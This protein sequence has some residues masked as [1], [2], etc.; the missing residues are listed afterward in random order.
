MV[1]GLIFAGPVFL[2]TGLYAVGSRQPQALQQRVRWTLSVSF[3]I[4][5][6]A[7]TALLLGAGEV[8][9]FFGDAYADSAGSTLRVLGLAVFPLIVRDHYVAIRRLSGRLS[10][11]A[12]FVGAGAVL[13]LALAAIGAKMGGVT[14]L[15]F[16]W[17]AAIGIEAVVMAD[18]VARLA[19]P[20]LTQ[21]LGSLGGWPRIP[22]CGAARLCDHAIPSQSKHTLGVE[23]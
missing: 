12:L 5:V 18:P 17:V 11:A 3:A 10:N 9:G 15:S 14:G 21:R 8:L 7:N 6:A 4:A 23:R 13:E 1:A 16:G 19:V 2:T 22:A 20:G